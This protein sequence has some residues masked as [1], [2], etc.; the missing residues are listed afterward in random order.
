MRTL[1]AA[2]AASALL[3]AAPAFA[4]VDAAREPSREA[5]RPG[6]QQ[7]SESEAP[8]GAMHRHPMQQ[9]RPDGKHHHRVTA[10][11]VYVPVGSTYAPYYF[12]S[13]PVYIDADPPVNAYRDLSGFYYWCPDPSGYYPYTVD[14]PIGWRLVAP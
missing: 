9:H 7:K 14:C 1:V 11:I 2:L 4:S 13:S 5:V 10:I 3:S 12:P 8:Q 6:A